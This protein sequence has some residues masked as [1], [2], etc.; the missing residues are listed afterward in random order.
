MHVFFNKSG[1]GARG[2]PWEAT[3]NDWEW[4]IEV[5]LWGVINS[6][7]VF[8]PLNGCTEHRVLYP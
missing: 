4:V 8:T 7:K 3:W 1:L 2:A 5:N 6:V